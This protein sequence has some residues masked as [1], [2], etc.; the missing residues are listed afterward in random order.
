VNI[1]QETGGTFLD[2]VLDTK[3]SFD[4]LDYSLQ[5]GHKVLSSTDR[6]RD[7]LYK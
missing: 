5:K 7:G 3:S 2:D 4:V 6:S 1:S